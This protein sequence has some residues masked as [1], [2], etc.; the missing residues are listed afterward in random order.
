MYALILSGHVI[1]A[2]ATIVLVAYALY[3]VVRGNSAQYRFSA[4]ALAG[5]ASF[6]VIS[7][8][9]LTLLSPELTALSL[10][11]HIV[12]YLG[13]CIAVEMLL[14][15]RMKENSMVFPFA[16]TASPMLIGTF[17]FGLALFAGA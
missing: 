16:V 6:E 9:V 4:L 17:V 14:F 3:I 13:I 7:G 11:P 8:T 1:A 5:V 15:M 10:V 12:S 2:I